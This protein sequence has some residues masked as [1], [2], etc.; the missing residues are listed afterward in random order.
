MRISDWSSD[1]CSSDLVNVSGVLRAYNSFLTNDARTAAG[2][3]ARA[4]ARQGWLDQ[5]QSYPNNDSQGLGGQLT[6]FYNAAQDLAAAPTSGSAR[7]AFLAPAGKVANQ[8][9]PLAPSFAGTRTGIRQDVDQ[10][11][12]RTT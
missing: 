5:I 4:A 9:R 8:F 12:A 3:Y 6:G 10:P 2:D 1:V 7:D 11:V